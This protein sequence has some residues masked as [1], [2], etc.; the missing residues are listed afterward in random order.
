MYSATLHIPIVLGIKPFK[1]RDG[2]SF[3]AIGQ[4][5]MRFT[6]LATPKIVFD[7]LT[8]LGDIN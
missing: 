2:W 6:Y 8:L 7:L 5:L 1:R 3:A 4:A